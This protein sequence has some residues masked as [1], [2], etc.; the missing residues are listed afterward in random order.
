MLQFVSPQSVDQR[1]YGS[2][3]LDSSEPSDRLVQELLFRQRHQWLERRLKPPVRETAAKPFGQE[4]Q[5]SAVRPQAAVSAV[6]LHQAHLAW[7]L[8]QQ[9]D[10]VDSRL[11]RRV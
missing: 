4:L 10:S 9:T 7:S 8:Q 6:R 5:Q 2:G 1:R 11:R 3:W